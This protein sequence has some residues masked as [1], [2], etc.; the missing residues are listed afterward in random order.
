M[1]TNESARTELADIFMKERLN[2][3]LKDYQE[4][5]DKAIFDQLNNMGFE[6]EYVLAHASDFY[7]RKYC[8]L[9]HDI[10]EFYHRG[11]HLF[12]MHETIHYEVDPEEFAHQTMIMKLY[13]DEVR[14]WN[15]DA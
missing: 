4:R 9:R 10:S 6:R 1:L 2:P 15:D 14:D 8:Q 12:T 11:E 13:F 3:I 5:R 7:I